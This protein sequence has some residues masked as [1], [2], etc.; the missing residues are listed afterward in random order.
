M[1]RHDA[2]EQHRP[3]TKPGIAPFGGGLPRGQ[4]QRSIADGQ[5]TAPLG[6]LVSAGQPGPGV[7]RQP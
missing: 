6:Q 7:M 5:Q 4:R 3:D 1:T 2:A